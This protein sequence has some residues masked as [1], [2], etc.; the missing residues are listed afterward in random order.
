M[1]YSVDADACQLEHTIALRKL[2]PWDRIAYY[3][4]VNYQMSNW[5]TPQ[6]WYAAYLLNLLH[7]RWLCYQADANG[8][9]YL[10]HEYLKRVIPW[11]YWRGVK[12]RLLRDGIIEEDCQSIAGQKC[13]GYRITSNYYNTKRYYHVNPKIIKRI[14][15]TYG[16][17][18]S[19]LP[20]HQWLRSKLAVLD[21][22][23]DRAF[24][25]IA[26][27]SPDEGSPMSVADYHI[28]LQET[29]NKFVDCEHYCELDRF[30]RIH[31]LITSLPKKLRCC[32]SVRGSYLMGSD[33]YNSQPLIAGLVACRYYGS[34]QARYTM[35]L[36]VF[37]KGNRNPYSYRAYQ[38]LPS[39]TKVP[40]DVREYLAVCQEGRMYESFMQPGDDRDRF[41]V[42]FYT[43]VL[44]GRNRIKSKV[45]SAF[46]GRYPSMAA[47]FKALKY[48]D[49]QRPAWIM[50]NVE[51]TLFIYNICGRVMKE[52]PKTMVFTIHDSLLAP[53]GDFGYVQRIA[54][55]EFARLGLQPKFH[56]ECYQ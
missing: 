15:L 49:Y 38:E 34:R 30:G 47:M 20:V 52:R 45:K 6:R 21:F 17:N 54:E 56:K 29:C 7:W 28:L 18:K 50:Q 14:K 10:K 4:P 22:D 53:P 5:P 55:E 11:V 41:K 1:N 31:T 8:F 23:K 35:P 48:K 39:L 46:F 19:L 44:F 2:V 43:D 26:G 42:K 36:E 40:A 12:D 9:V 13:C 3:W 32:L 24:D 37:A 25:I 51:S 33:L 16:D 27:M